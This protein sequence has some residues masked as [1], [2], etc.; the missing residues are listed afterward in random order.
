VVK[1]AV[2]HDGFEPG[3]DVLQGIS[4]GWPAVL[5]SPKTLLET[6]TALQGS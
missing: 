1:L 6:G 4:N 5:A 3:S 2:V